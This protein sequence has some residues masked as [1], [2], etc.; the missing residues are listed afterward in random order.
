MQVP[1]R[2]LLLAPGPLRAP[3]SENKPEHKPGRTSV[4]RPRQ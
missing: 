4:G 3:L 2:Q 1:L